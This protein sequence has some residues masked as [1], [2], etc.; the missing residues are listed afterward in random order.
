ME[1][2]KTAQEI[3]KER[4]KENHDK[5]PSP[6]LLALDE[7]TEQDV[8]YIV[9]SKRVHDVMQYSVLIKHSE[10]DI[11]VNEWIKNIIFLERE[12]TKE[13]IKAGDYDLTIS[14]FDA[15]F[16]INIT[17]TEDKFNVNSVSPI[18]RL[19]NSNS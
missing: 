2:K 17:V 3:I 19:F 18:I 14:L 9:I 11:I 7:V 4:F 10:Y 12:R 6:P 13:V 1:K 5:L 8:K 16:M 15:P